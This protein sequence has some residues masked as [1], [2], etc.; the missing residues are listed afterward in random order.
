[1]LLKDKWPARMLKRSV[2]PTLREDPADGLDVRTKYLFEDAALLNKLRQPGADRGLLSAVPITASA[3][4]VTPGSTSTTWLPCPSSVTGNLCR[5][6]LSSGRLAE[7]RRRCRKLV[8]LYKDKHLA[9]G[10]YVVCVLVANNGSLVP[11]NSSTSGL[12]KRRPA[13]CTQCNLPAV[14][15]NV[16][17]MH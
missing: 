16:Q 8:V 4:A 1:M 11:D 12:R 17:Y 7:D 3:G 9:Q 14:L 10:V 13:L 2:D 6:A 5:G 15:S